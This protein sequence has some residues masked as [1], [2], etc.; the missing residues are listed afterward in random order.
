MQ[1][2]IGAG[3]AVGQQLAKELSQFTDSIRLVSRN[4]KKV[5]EQDELFPADATDSVQLE[6]A[7]Q[8]SEVVYLTIGFEYN[9]NIWKQNWPPLMKNL[10]DA[11]KKHNAKLVFF[12]NVYMYDREHLN[13]MTEETPVRPTSRKGHVRA[14]I[15]NMLMSEVEKGD[16]TAL[17]ARAADF[18]GPVNSLVTEL[19]CK[20]LLKG[21]KAT[22]F[23]DVKKLHNFTHT[24][25]AA[26]GTAILGNTPDAFNQVWH[27]PTDTTPLTAN[28][29]IELFAKE[30]GTRPKYMV[31]PVWMMG[32]FGLLMPVIKEFKE[33][34]YQYDRDYVFDSTKFETKFDYKPLIPEEAVKQTVREVRGS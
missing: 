33:M 24:S 10:I 7:V 12:D 1:T 16:L 8:G 5:N 28:E 13:P 22:W 15:A 6:T 3:G 11:C 23:A 25:D 20:N 26:K 14:H 17:I 29:W 4:P 18:I 27:L 34:S 19:V 2:I 31:M 30:I 21:K 9:I 32:F